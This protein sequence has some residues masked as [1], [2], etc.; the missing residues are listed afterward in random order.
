MPN[1]DNNLVGYVMQQTKINY[2]SDKRQRC[3]RRIS[4]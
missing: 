1:V 3:Q 2:K 4:S